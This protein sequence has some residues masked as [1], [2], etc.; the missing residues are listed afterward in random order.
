MIA[1]KQ[2]S[3]PAQSLKWLDDIKLINFTISK[4]KMEPTECRASPP[5]QGKGTHDQRA[6]SRRPCK[7]TTDEMAVK[8]QK[9]LIM[10]ILEMHP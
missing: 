7:P 4:G 8:S 10:N 3:E 6:A 5:E 9:K 1:E 2:Y